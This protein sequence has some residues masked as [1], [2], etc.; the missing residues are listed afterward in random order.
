ML[1]RLALVN[2]V[3]MGE[4]LAGFRFRFRPILITVSTP[5]NTREIIRK[6][7]SLKMRLGEFLSFH[8]P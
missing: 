6:K 3:V 5:T 7:K 4:H 8:D 1:D 2:T